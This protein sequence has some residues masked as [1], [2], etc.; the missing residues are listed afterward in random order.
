[1]KEGDVL[2]FKKIYVEITNCCNMHCSFCIQNSRKQ[3]FMSC[4]EFTH[5]IKEIKPYTE[6]IYLHVL[7]EPL[8]HPEI[9][10]FMQIAD[11]H[12]LYVQL[13]TN[14]TLIENCLDGLCHAANLRQ[15]NISVHSFTQY[16]ES[17]QIAYLNKIANAARSLSVAGKYVS[18]RLWNMKDNK[19]SDETLTAIHHFEQLFNIHIEQTQRRQSVKLMKQVFLQFDD[20]FEWPDLSNPYVSD[21]GRCLGWKQMCAILCDGTIVPCCLDSKGTEVLGNIFKES[22]TD[23]LNNKSNLTI[24]DELKSGKIK[25][26]L[27]KH[28]SYRLRFNKGGI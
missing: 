13:T 20:V 16:D 21:T 12:G 19:A 23:I 4:E 1:M 10:H 27:C 8:L 6:M 14:G 18:L 17:E 15:I 9:F 22:F 2:R 7:G 11:E 3:H 5:I 28:C 26:E 24:L 25:C